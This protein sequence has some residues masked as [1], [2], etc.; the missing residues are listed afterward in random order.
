MKFFTHE[1]FIGLVGFLFLFPVFLTGVGRFQI[2]I[3]GGISYIHPED[4]NLFSK[5]EEQYNDIYFIQHFW[6]A[7]GY[8][9]NDFPKINMPPAAGL[10]LKYWV[11]DA[12]ALSF[13]AEGFIQSKKT[14]IEG[15]FTYS[16]SWSESQTKKYDPYSLKLSALALLGGIHYR[17]SLGSQT[18]LEV[19]AAAGWTM[20]DFDFS[21]TW[22]YEAEYQDEE[23][24]FS[25]IDS[26]TLEGDG[27]GNGFT[28][29]GIL[30]LSRRVG[31]RFG[32][33]VET[34]YT[35][36]RITSVEG[37]GREMRQGIPGESTWEGSWGIKKEEIQTLW[38]S[39]AVTVPTNY[40]GDWTGA[41]RERDFVL[42]LSGVRLVIGFLLRL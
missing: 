1:V 4:F 40:W 27:S 26:G 11:S 13:G 14:S 15:T 18:D 42:N 8:F 3:Y 19:G 25:T 30:R 7:N 41:Q 12:L 16:P 23:I 17:W 6:Y 37:T 20:A 31:K 33:F 10:R 22:S 21:S 9:V 5:A 28:A 29:Q 36:C 34:A 39:A 2:D 24:Y 38:G 35:F 32:F